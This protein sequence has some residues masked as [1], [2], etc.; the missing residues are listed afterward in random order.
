LVDELEPSKYIALNFRQ[1]CSVLDGKDWGVE[2]ARKDRTASV[3]SQ[4]NKTHGSAFRA[5]T[6]P[7]P[8]GLVFEFTAPFLSR[9][10]EKRLVKL[11]G[12]HGRLENLIKGYAVLLDKGFDKI[13]GW[14]PNYNPIYHP[15]F[16][17]KG[18]FNPE[19]IRFNLTVCQN[20]YTCEVVYSRVN[21][22]KGIQG[23]IKRE[24][25]H[26]F[27]DMMNWAHGR[28]NLYLP[29]QTPARHQDYFPKPKKGNTRAS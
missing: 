27:E 28:A 26:W 10:S 29:L 15:A 7:L 8:I 18:K 5:V 20:R 9:A 3:G 25:S 2:T 16:L 1:V 13:N 24:K 19:Q 6:W 17:T 21:Q 4:S 23:V 14:L 12:K 11:W 22:V